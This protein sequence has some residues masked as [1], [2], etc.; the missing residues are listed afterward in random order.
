VTFRRLQICLTVLAIGTMQMAF[1][2]NTLKHDPFERPILTSTVNS[3]PV[4]ANVSVQEEVPWNPT[5]S[6]VMV[7]GKNSLINLD[8]A[9]MKLGE[10]KD[11][12]RL[13]QVKDRE[14]LLIK[15]KKRVTLSIKASPIRA[16]NEAVVDTEKTMLR[17]KLEPDIRP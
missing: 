7:A 4:D 12:Y 17:S 3:T 2:D 14:A 9:I 5:L 6:A 1:A 13:I 16:G 10:E 11:G 15:G 8:G